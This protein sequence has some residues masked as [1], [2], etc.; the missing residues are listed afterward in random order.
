LETGHRQFSIEA[1]SSHL[2]SPISKLFAR[3]D[4]H[5]H[6]NL[7]PCSRE[8]M[9]LQDIIRAAEEQGIEHLAITDHI[10]P[11]T[12]RSII[13]HVRGQCNRLNSTM[14]IYVGCEADV[15]AV[16]EVTV[17]PALADRADFVMVAANHFQDRFISQP[18]TRK[19]RDVALHYLEMLRFAASLELADVIAH[20]LF[21]VPGTYDPLAPAEL[22][23]EDLLPVVELAARNSIA[24][25][26]SRRAL[27][28]EQRPFLLSFYRLCKQAGLKFAIGSDAHQ[29]AD[30]GRTYLVEPLILE[31]G[32]T[33]EDIWLPKGGYSS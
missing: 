31:L 12:D 20:P 11:S 22:T 32:L 5:V 1:P 29:L 7:S 27:A 9:T 33:D 10:H 16:G 4:L 14:N 6:T 30:V 2:S 23:E 21:V 8:E 18:P 24:V 15:V 25:E 3:C 28:P 17:D 26:I 19:S 13:D